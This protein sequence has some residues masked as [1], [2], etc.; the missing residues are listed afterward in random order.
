SPADFIRLSSQYTVDR[1]LERDD[2][3]KRYK[4]NQSIAIHEL[5]YPLVQGY[6]SVA[7]KADVELCGTDQ[8]FNLLIG[9]ELQRA[10]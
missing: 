1:M 4:S 9:R 5:L 8:K 2:F 6:D 10:Y 3:D 7:L